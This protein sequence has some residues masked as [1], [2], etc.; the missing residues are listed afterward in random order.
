M[1]MQYDKKTDAMYIE[2]SKGTYKKSRK[3]TDAIVVDEDK[4]GNVLGIEILDATEHIND[5]NPNKISI[6]S[7]S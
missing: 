7:V 4:E 5:F 2:L 6:S 1:K 3:I